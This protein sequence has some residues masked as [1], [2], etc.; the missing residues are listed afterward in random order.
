M[1]RKYWEKIAP[2]YDEE[3]FDVLAND[4]KG[5]ILSA[6]K[7]YA[8]QTKTVTDAGCAIGKWLPV[9]SPRFRQVLAVDISAK[10]LSIAR[11]KYADLPNIK[12]LRADL[13]SPSIKLPAA[14]IVVCI[15]A[16]LSDSLKKRKNFFK[17]LAAG[18]KKDGYL[19]LVVPSLESWFLTKI[20]QHQWQI[21][22]EVF[23]EKLSGREGII[24]YRNVLQGNLE[25]DNVPTKH[26]LE[27][28][29]ALLLTKEKFSVIDCKK[30]EYSWTTEF[31]K[32]PSWLKEPYPWDW[33]VVARKK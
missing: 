16:I 28:E 31:L 32:P 22:K 1:E 21:D 6:I 30:I 4:K 12:Y 24:K 14:E 5:F 3:I 20:I 26:Y 2:D 29:L 8:S 27:E 11:N 25:I 17:N 19:I 9:L 33:L 7:K 23:S 15:N 10:N 13:S 18:L